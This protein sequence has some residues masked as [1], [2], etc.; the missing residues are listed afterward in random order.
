MGR[1]GV[2]RELI[3]G[4]TMPRRSL[5]RLAINRTGN[6]TVEGDLGGKR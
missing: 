3:Q 5:G 1:E 6:L 2:N 4:E